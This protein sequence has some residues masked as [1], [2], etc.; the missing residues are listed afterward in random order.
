MCEDYL[1]VYTFPVTCD[2]SANFEFATPPEWKDS[3]LM[4]GGKGAKKWRFSPSDGRDFTIEL[5]FKDNRFRGKLKPG[6][7]HVENCRWFMAGEAILP[8]H[9]PDMLLRLELTCP[10]QQAEAADGTPNG[11]PGN[12]EHGNTWLCLDIGNTRT[13]ALGWTSSHQH[14]EEQPL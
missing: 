9:F 3:P 13:S 6:M 8:L 11:G 10:E 14:L 7:R 5:E 4:A 2:R 12:E 1:R